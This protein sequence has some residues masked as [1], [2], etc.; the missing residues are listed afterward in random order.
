[1]PELPG[2]TLDDF[3]EWLERW[4]AAESP[5]DDRVLRVSEWIMSRADDP[6]VGARQVIEIPG[7]WFAEISGTLRDD[8]KVTCSYW[9][10][11]RAHVVR[12]DNI[13]TLSPPFI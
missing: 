2:W 9:I 3:S 13:Q 4:I 11:E 6:Y 7:L 8:M 1:M 10:N 12:C 5:D